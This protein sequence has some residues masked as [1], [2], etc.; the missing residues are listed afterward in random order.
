MKCQVLFSLKN[1]T[2]SFRMSSA[3]NLLSTFRVK[4][5]RKRYLPQVIHNSS[6]SSSSSD[7]LLTC[8]SGET[9]TS[10]GPLPGSWLA[11]RMADL[12]SDLQVCLSWG[13]IAE[14]FHSLSA[15]SMS[16]WASQAHAFHQPVGQR[17]SWLHHW[18]VQYVYYPT[19]LDILATTY[20]S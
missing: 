17:L 4:T 14:S 12:T 16:S 8:S 5:H 1:N 9:S 19:Q 18:S 13:S 11:T 6:S 15:V 20:L 3:T 10:V 7:F 2:I